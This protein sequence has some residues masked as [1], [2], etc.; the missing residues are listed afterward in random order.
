MRSMLLASLLIST[1][2]HSACADDRS[3]QLPKDGA[4]PLTAPFDATQ[5][6]AA[7][8]AWARSLG[9]SSPVEKNSTGMELVLIPP[10]KFTM[11]SPQREMDR[12]RNEDQVEVTL[13][14]AFY[15]GKT[16]VTQLQ[17]RAVMGTMPWTMGSEFVDWKHVR[18]GDD[19]PAS[20]VSWDDARVFCE[21]LSEKEDVTYRLPTEAEWEFA[22]RG[23]TVT[24][25]SFGDD[26]SE[27][28]EHGWYKKNASA[29]REVYA[30]EVGQKRANLFGLHDMHGNVFE[31]CEDVFAKQLPG[32]S[33]PLVSDGKPFKVIRGGC[34]PY[35]GAYCRSA[36]RWWHSPSTRLFFLGF[37]VA[38]SSSDLAG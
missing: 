8:E 31:W 25:F 34:C 36:F 14:K 13:T 27:L 22:C 11:G 9:K 7:Q 24:R 32:G 3:D 15:I 33:D 6:K 23:G 38:R 12:T 29:N 2:T 5:A 19:F 18:E 35:D 16:E 20:H 30:R 17:W 37:R 1:M 10:G 21:K 26:E 28:G 4:L